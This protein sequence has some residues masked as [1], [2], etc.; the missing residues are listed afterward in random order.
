[1]TEVVFHL[2][3]AQKRSYPWGHCYWH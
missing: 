3:G 2:I 1:M